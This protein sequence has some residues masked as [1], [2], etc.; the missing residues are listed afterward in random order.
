MAATADNF[1]SRMDMG[2]KGMDLDELAVEQL[3]IMVTSLDEVVVEEADQESYKGMLVYEEEDEEDEEDEEVEEVEEVEEDAEY[4]EYAVDEEAEEA[5]EAEEY[6]EDAESEEAEG[7]D[8]DEEGEEVD[9]MVDD[10]NDEIAMIRAAPGNRYQGR[11]IAVEYGGALIDLDGK[12]SGILTVKESAA[13]SLR[14]MH[15]L[16]EVG[17]S[18]DVE[19]IQSENYE[20]RPVLSL[21]RIQVRDSWD[22]VL[23]RQANDETLDGV[24]V[25]VNR[26]GCI[27]TVDGLRAFLP[28]SHCIGGNPSVDMI[29]TT[30]PVK[31]IEVNVDIGKIV[32]SN[33]R[34]VI[35]NELADLNRGDVIEGVVSGVRPYGVFVELRG[36]M[37]GLLHISQV[38]YERVESLDSI[39]YDGMRVKVM[40]IDH[41]KV[42]GRV[43]L[44]TKTLEAEPGDLIRDPSRVFESAEANA[45]QYHEKMNLERRAREEVAMNIVRGLREEGEEVSTIVIKILLFTYL[46][47]RE[48]I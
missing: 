26:G 43:A 6:V 25:A 3:E 15:N 47:R 37:S 44:S 36:G 48:V 35:E 13:E 12:S 42:N 33:R 9:N 34:A 31:F 10:V 18:I 40:V 7:Y 19:V 39:F 8:E 5:E 2:Y 27:C 1:F 30:I 24:I 29:G 32:V 38:S 46:M 28:G 45:L 21:R 41:D 22:R 11:V 4:E 16:L 17:Q 20:G 14:D 23:Q